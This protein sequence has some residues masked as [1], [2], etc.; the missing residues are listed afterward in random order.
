MSDLIA[1][2]R[3]KYETDVELGSERTHYLHG[4]H[5][6]MDKG[7]SNFSVHPGFII[8][9]CDREDELERALLKMK[10]ELDA[11][12]E[13]SLLLEQHAVRRTIEKEQA[14][15]LAIDAAHEARLAAFE[16]AATIADECAAHWRR[17]YPRGRVAHHLISTGAAA[18]G[19]KIRKR[20]RGE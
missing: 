16:E 13:K 19:M 17:E 5:M 2:I 12:R 8:E 1:E 4:A 10:E 20:A 18:I 3:E 9:R 7:A 14:E 15:R 11:Y 6:A